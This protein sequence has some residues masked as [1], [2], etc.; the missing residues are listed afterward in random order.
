MF[1]VKEITNAFYSFD[2]ARQS[3]IDDG[4]AITAAF[5]FEGITYE[6]FIERKKAVI[7]ML[8][9]EKLSANADSAKKMIERTLSELGIESPKA[10]S[11]S[12]VVKSAQREKVKA[13]VS[14]IAKL[15]EGKSAEEILQIAGKSDAKTQKVLSAI[16]LNLTDAAENETK[17]ALKARVKI[18]TEKVKSVGSTEIL[19]RAEVLVFASFYNLPDYIATL[20]DELAKAEVEAEAEAEA[21]AKA[22]AEAKA[23]AVA[24]AKAKAKK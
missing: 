13:E 10:T 3:I 21:T 22:V 23:K 7:E 1:E 12:A 18:L 17:K 9:S 11:E 14:A 16:A 8:V 24:E 6:V 19:S 2:C 20:K 4:K 5:Q 15:H